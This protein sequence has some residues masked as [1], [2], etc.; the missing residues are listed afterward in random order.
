MFG[1]QKALLVVRLAMGKKIARDEQHGVELSVH[2]LWDFLTSRCTGAIG[3][4]LLKFVFGGVLITPR[5]RDLV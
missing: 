4:K 5:P 2:A 1:Y 3:F